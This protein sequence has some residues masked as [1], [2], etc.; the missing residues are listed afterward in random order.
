MATRDPRL[1]EPQSREERT[2][3]H[4]GFNR[5]SA[6]ILSPNGRFLAV[7]PRTADM[8]LLLCDVLS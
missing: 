3:S 8:T 7:V 6:L 2:V 4:P 1:W 5:I